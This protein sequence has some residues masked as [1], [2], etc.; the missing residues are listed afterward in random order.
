LI[1]NALIHGELRYAETLPEML[2]LVD[3]VMKDLASESSV[4]FYDPGED[5]KFMLSDKRHMGVGVDWPNNFLQIA[6]NVSTG[7]GG[8]IWFVTE[9]YPEKGGIY[10]S[11]WVSD[12]PSPPS[13]DPRV[14]SDPGEPAFHDP[15]SA[16][17]IPLVRQAVEEFCRAGTGRRPE[18]IGWVRSYVSGYRIQD[19]VQ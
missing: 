15:R 4:P 19:D 17:P 3:I 16:I 6:V 14:V 8:L 18:S 5:A 12:N 13:F 11:V 7:Y 1:L 2:A 9:D 10:E